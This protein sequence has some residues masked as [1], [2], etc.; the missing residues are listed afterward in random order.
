VLLAVQDQADI[1][2]DQLEQPTLLRIVVGQRLQEGRR[3][4]NLRVARLPGGF[5]A[6]VDRVFF[7]D[8][9]AEQLELAG[10]GDGR[11]R[12]ELVADVLL[13]DL[14]GFLPRKTLSPTGGERVGRSP[15]YS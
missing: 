8:G 2:V 11:E 6:L 1:D 15:D 10:L 3:Y 7:A 12:L 9:L 4:R 5:L 13:V 14:H